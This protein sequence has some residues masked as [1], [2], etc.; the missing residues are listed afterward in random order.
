MNVRPSRPTGLGAQPVASDHPSAPLSAP[1]SHATE[2]RSG[3][4]T[5]TATSSR[6]SVVVLLARASSPQWIARLSIVHDRID[7]AGSNDPLAVTDQVAVREHVPPRL[8]LNIGLSFHPV[9]HLDGSREVH[10]EPGGDET[11]T[12]TSDGT[13][14]VTESQIRQGHQHGTVRSTSR[15]GMSFFDPHAEGRRYVLP[16]A[17]PQRTDNAEKRAGL[18]HLESIRDVQFVERH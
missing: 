11:K 5:L 14:A 16:T 3:L 8:V 10:C 15:I 6:R 7:T 18:E 4:P 13:N 2:E 12:A 17:D 9:A 1:S